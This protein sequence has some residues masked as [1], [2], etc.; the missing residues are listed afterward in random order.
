VDIRH[1]L[2][3]KGALPSTKQSLVPS[4]ILKGFGFE[5]FNDTRKPAQQSSDAHLSPVLDH[6]CGVEGG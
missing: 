6:S 3:T 1:L 5:G 4:V 2:V